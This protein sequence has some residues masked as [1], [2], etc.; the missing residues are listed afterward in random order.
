LTH[1][2]KGTNTTLTISGL[3]AGDV[4]HVWL[5][6]HANNT[7]TAERAHGIWSTT[8]PTSSAS[9]Q[10]IDGLSTHNGSTWEDGTNYVLF[11]NVQADGSGRIVLVGDATDAGELGA[12]QPAYRLPLNGF[13]LRQYGLEPPS[14]FL[15]WAA[16]PVNGLTPGL[17]DGPND[18]PD[19]DGLANRLEFVLGSHPME[20]TPANFQTLKPGEGS[21]WIY[22][23]DRSNASAPPATTQIVEYGS[24]LS[25]WT[26]VPIPA[27]SAGIVTVTPGSPK[28]RVSVAL[29][30]LGESGFVRLRVSE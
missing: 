16:D 13:Q 8:H 1:F 24:G 28:D 26:Q 25:G 20:S 11:E 2:N 23:Y 15:V 12:G 3:T 4:Y 22:E 18:D 27:T 6:S 7:T 9:A 17:N 14:P 21:G 19:H 30:N 10:T 29:P 5:A